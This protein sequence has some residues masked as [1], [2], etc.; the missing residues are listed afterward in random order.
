MSTEDK[1]LEALNL[2]EAEITTTDRDLAG[3]A[4]SLCASCKKIKDPMESVLALVEKFPFVGK[5]V[6][7]TIRFLL[8]VADGVCSEVG[9]V[10][11]SRV[12]RSASRDTHS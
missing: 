12:S 2:I 3:T 8:K 10:N 6:A 4:A 11:S 5:R 9:F 7:N 1:A